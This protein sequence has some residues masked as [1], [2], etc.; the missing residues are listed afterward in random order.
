MLYKDIIITIATIVSIISTS[1]VSWKAYNG[2][3][4]NER[5]KF[6][7]V[8]HIVI[9]LLSLL[10]GVLLLCFLLI[11]EL[12]SDEYITRKSVFTICFLTVSIPVWFIAHY[13]Y[14]SGKIENLRH[15]RFE[16]LID[17]LKVHVDEFKET[18]SNDT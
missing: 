16:C 1:I 3:K 8:S 7:S 18:K 11:T 17:V 9:V 15:E 12:S 14:I 5:N 6:R 2:M 10:S 13:L 4:I